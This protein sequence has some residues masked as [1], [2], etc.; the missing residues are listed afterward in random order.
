MDSNTSLAGETSSSGTIGIPCRHYLPLQGLPL[1]QRRRVLLAYDCSDSSDYAL[2]WAFR[3]LLFDAKDHLILVSV[4]DSPIQLVNTEHF[5]LKSNDEIRGDL[6]SKSTKIHSILDEFTNLCHARNIST[7][8]YVLEG[9]PK[10]VILDV[11]ERSRCSMIV[12]GARGMSF[13]QRAIFGSTSSYVSKHASIPVVIVKCESKSSLRTCQPIDSNIQ[14]KSI[15][16]LA[17]NNLEAQKS[18]FNDEKL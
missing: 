8:K 15:K 14:W 9:D 11:A 18:A 2:E 13:V 4:H 16:E 3:N 12:L 5:G 10:K 7:Q 1:E 17:M 6:N